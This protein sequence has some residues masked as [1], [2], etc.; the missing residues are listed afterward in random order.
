MLLTTVMRKF[1]NLPAVVVRDVN[2]DDGTLRVEV[3]RQSKQHRCPC[4]KFKAT[5][6]YDGH[7]RESRH[8]PLGR[9]RVVLY[10]Y[11]ARIAC[12]K[13]GVVTE[14]VAWAEPGSRGR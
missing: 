6:R 13:N 12:P 10:G 9:W 7:W 4:C 1:L 3:E 14:A 2:F 8:V 11:L 5:G